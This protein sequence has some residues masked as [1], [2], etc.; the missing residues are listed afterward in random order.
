MSLLP[1][2]TYANAGR[3]LWAVAGSGGASSLQSPASVIPDGA[4][5]VSLEMNGTGTGTSTLTLFPVSGAATIILNAQNGEDNAIHFLDPASDGIAVYANDASPNV[6]SIGDL[7]ANVVATFDNGNNT[8]T[9]GSLATVGTVECDAELFVKTSSSAVNSLGLYPVNAGQSVI[10]QTIANSGIVSVGSSA[11]YPETLN[12]SD[13]AKNG[14]ATY[15]EINGTAG[16]TPLFISAAQGVGGACY[17]YPDS[18]AGAGSLNLGSDVTNFETLKLTN[19]AV[20]VGSLTVPPVYPCST[21][22]VGLAPSGGSNARGQGTY[23]MTL[24]SLPDGMYTL[25][26]YPVPGSAGPTDLLTL[27]A[28]F[29]AQFIVKNNLC[30]YGGCGTN[31]TGEVRTFPASGLASIT[32]DINVVGNYYIAVDFFQLSGAVPGV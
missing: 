31:S 2:D 11:A 32:L 8:V 4:G 22:R 20:T 29:S 27:G 23:P 13:I 18:A 25:M 26:V 6:L 1:N 15:V 24:A 14:S 21:A 9:L 3:A 30:V 10:T 12:V 16:A 5:D 17:M 28:C 19:T 7:S